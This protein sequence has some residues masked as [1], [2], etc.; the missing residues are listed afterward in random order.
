MKG[1]DGKGD[2]DKSHD[3]H[4]E[5][6]RKFLLT[7]GIGV[8]GIGGAA[9]VLP[10]VCFMFAPMFEPPKQIW[11][12]VGDVGDFKIGD[13]VLVHYKDPSSLPWSGVT[14]NTASWLRRDNETEFTAFS[15]NCTHLGCPVR[16]I[17]TAGLF[18]CPC[19]GGVYYKDGTVAAGPPPLPLPRYPARLDPKTR[20]VQIRTSPIPFSTSERILGGV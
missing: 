18:M 2:D 3:P 12:D 10:T 14:A 9:V 16:W 17:Q 15:V 19:H 11:Q 5:A 1:D 4:G 6:R 7:A 8:S 13:T 20:L